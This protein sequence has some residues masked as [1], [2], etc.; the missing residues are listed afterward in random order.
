MQR[1][2][3]SVSAS[4]LLALGALFTGCGSE[5][6]YTSYIDGSDF[7]DGRTH[8]AS[9]LVGLVAEDNTGPKAKNWE[10]YYEVA[11]S[12]QS[13]PRKN[14]KLSFIRDGQYA[15]NS[16]TAVEVLLEKKK[17][18]FTAESDDVLLQEMVEYATMKVVEHPVTMTRGTRHK[19]FTVE[20][21]HY[22]Y[23][24]L[25]GFYDSEMR[26]LGIYKDS[27]KNEV[28]RYP[29]FD[30]VPKGPNSPA[31]K[32]LKAFYDFL[33]LKSATQ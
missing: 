25:A 29:D 24:V 31:M 28:E 27:Y 21:Y 6:A 17:H 18:K 19:E 20:T 12:F 15:A 33:R 10:P 9:V 26:L 11:L 30:P 16:S 22:R 1:F 7:T 3:N 14:L 23:D 4:S 13:G 5:G 8:K 32:Q 2:F